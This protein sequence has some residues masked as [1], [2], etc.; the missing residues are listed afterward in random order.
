MSNH[1]DPVTGICTPSTL[2]ELQAVGTQIHEHAEII[3]IGDPMC[4][5]C[6]GISPALIQLRNHF[7]KQQLAFRVVVGG[8][9]PGGGEPWNDEMKSFLRHHW[10]QVHTQSGQPFS[11]DLL[12][13]DEF[14]YDTEPA[15]RAV[16]AARTLLNEKEMEFFEAIQKKF[17]AESEDPT[18]S[19]FYESI[20]TSFDIDFSDFKN[21][22]ESEESKKETMQEFQLN[23]SWGVTG[24]PAVILLAKDKL[25]MVAQGFAG[26]DQMKN[27]IDHWLTT[28]AN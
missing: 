21:K 19:T 22:F 2:A 12:D 28:V 13:R 8:L 10:E 3:Y 20:C 25:Y 15:C 23:R 9:R 6:W 7:R 26:F 17:Y 16:I 24:Y 14:N 11:Y 4:S 18:E 1:C 5:W 27:T